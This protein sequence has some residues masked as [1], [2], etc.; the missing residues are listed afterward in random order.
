MVTNFCSKS[1]WRF[2]GTRRQVSCAAAALTGQR[3]AYLP[4]HPFRKQSWLSGLNA[5]LVQPGAAGAHLNAQVHAAREDVQDTQKSRPDHT[6]GRASGVVLCP[7]CPEQKA[8]ADRFCGLRGPWPLLE[9]QGSNQ[10]LVQ[11]TTLT[12]SC[13]KAS[14]ASCTSLPQMGAA[15]RAVAA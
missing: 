8:H 9:P 11:S 5:M 14:G 12:G 3:T 1:G 10:I 13:M 7:G 6:E 2:S 4:G 15:C